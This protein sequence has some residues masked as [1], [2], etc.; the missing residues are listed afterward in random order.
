MDA[1]NNGIKPVLRDPRS[2]LLIGKA[3]AEAFNIMGRD[4][5]GALIAGLIYWVISRS[6]PFVGSILLFL[7]LVGFLGWAEA[8]WSGRP[9]PVWMI[10]KVTIA[11]SGSVMGWAVLVV[12]LSL[13]PFVPATIIHTMYPGSPAPANTAMCAFAV[14]Y[15]LFEPAMAGQGVWWTVGAIVVLIPLVVSFAAISAWAIAVTGKFLPSFGW[16]ALRLFR[17]PLHWWL[18]GAFQLV[19]W[20]FISISI[21]SILLI[22][23]VPW[24][25]LFW[26]GVVRV[27]EATIP[28]TKPEDT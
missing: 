8:R 20:G 9:A 26:A 14:P 17:Y 7:F 27:G 23:L 1:G 13:V 4:I 3:F 21:T 22:V 6:L 5:A 2:R 18:I 12:L 16:A 15:T 11:N 10:W 25:A 28:L 19:I 24:F